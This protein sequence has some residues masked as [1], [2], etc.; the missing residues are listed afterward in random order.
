MADSK[1][2]GKVEAWIVRNV[3]PAIYG[4]PFRKATMRLTWGG[5]FEFDAVSADGK[6]VG[7]VST[8]CCLTA[9]GRQAIGKYHKIRADVLFL[10]N[11]E[12]AERRILIFTDKQMEAHFERERTRGRFPPPSVIEM[13]T[14]EIP[15]ELAAELRKAA[16]I[17]SIEVSPRPL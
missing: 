8:A 13:R 9:G 4:Q 1:V 15:D 3:L 14:V 10:L 7:C 16:A 6:I 11:A 5:T 2:Q 17:A 12:A